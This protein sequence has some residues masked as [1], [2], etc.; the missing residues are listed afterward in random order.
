MRRKS[1]YGWLFKHIQRQ[2][3]RHRQK[4]FFGAIKVKSLTIKII[5]QEGMVLLGYC[6]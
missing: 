5:L 2:N 6:H 4:Q 3:H 1:I